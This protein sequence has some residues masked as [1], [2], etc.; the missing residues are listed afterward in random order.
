MNLLVVGKCTQ[1]KNTCYLL[2]LQP[3]PGNNGSAEL[4]S[5]AWFSDKNRFLAGVK[6]KY[7]HSLGPVNHGMTSVTVWTLGRFL[8]RCLGQVKAA[9]VPHDPVNGKNQNAGGQNPHC[10]YQPQ[11]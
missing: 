4:F 5:E 6:E 2:S 10:A 11:S 8:E 1:V 9:Y 3:A 7:L